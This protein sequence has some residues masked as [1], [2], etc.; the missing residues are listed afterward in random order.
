MTGVEHWTMRG[1]VKVACGEGEDL[2]L[3][4]ESGMFGTFAQFTFNISTFNSY[5][6]HQQVQ[7]PVSHVHNQDLRWQNVLL[8]LNL[9]HWSSTHRPWGSQ[10]LLRSLLL[11]TY[12]TF[13]CFFSLSSSFSPSLHRFLPCLPSGWKLKLKT[14]FDMEPPWIQIWTVILS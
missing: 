11:I 2:Q 7:S 3:F 5:Q 12:A 13:S 14:R 1:G 4:G 8:Q 10:H 6:S 9:G